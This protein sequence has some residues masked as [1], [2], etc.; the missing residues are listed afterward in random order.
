MERVIDEVG[1]LVAD[2]RRLAGGGKVEQAI[3]KVEDFLD[4]HPEE[5]RVWRTLGVLQAVGGHQEQALLSYDNSLK[6]SPEDPETLVARAKLLL[7]MERVEEGREALEAAA[8]R[9]ERRPFLLASLAESASPLGWD[10]VHQLCDQALAADPK[11]AAAWLA[12]GAAHQAQGEHEESVEAYE[13]ARGLSPMQAKAWLGKGMSLAA[14]EQ[15]HEAAHCL[16]QSVKLGGQLAPV[17]DTLTS[18]LLRLE[19]VA[20]AKAVLRR[21]WSR[22]EADEAVL[23]PVLSRIHL[24]RKEL[25]KARFATSEAVRLN[26]EGQ[27]ILQLKS[28]LEAELEEQPAALL[29]ADGTLA[30]TYESSGSAAIIGDFYSKIFRLS[31]PPD[32]NRLKRWSYLLMAVC[33]PAVP[34]AGEFLLGWPR[35]QT[36]LATVVAPV[37]LFVLGSVAVKAT[38]RG[39][40]RRVRLALSQAEAVDGVVAE[41]DHGRLR[42]RA[43]HAQT[44]YSAVFR[45]FIGSAVPGQRVRFLVAPEEAFCF[46]GLTSNESETS[47]LDRAEL[48]SAALGRFADRDQ[49]ETPGVAF[50]LMALELW[51]SSGLELDS[52]VGLVNGWAAAALRRALQKPGLEELTKFVA[53]RSSGPAG[54][55]EDGESEWVLFE[56]VDLSPESPHQ[57]LYRLLLSRLEFIHRTALLFSGGER[58]ALRRLLDGQVSEEEMERLTT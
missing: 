48:M 23:L 5:G 55:A 37:G 51:K 35:W 45:N 6:W 9:A 42:V 50:E 20:D 39:D 41:F 13:K 49:D 25:L 33:T 15:H 21:A 29:F 12:K 52:R 22:P 44:E 54:P 24:D 1:E 56:K 7:T 46:A 30:Q 31:E 17:V 34:I 26:G 19:R 16:E 36:G 53:D 4:S 28:E 3:A 40:E 8:T 10:R 38:L 32:G 2:C 58:L 47:V 14:L 43:E 11:I 57:G 18:C 27:R